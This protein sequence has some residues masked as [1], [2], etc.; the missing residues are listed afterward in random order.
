MTKNRTTF[1]EYFFIDFREEKKQNN[2]ISQRVHMINL[3]SKPVGNHISD[4]RTG[5]LHDRLSKLVIRA[6]LLVEKYI[7]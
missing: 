3:M 4:D 6:S 1:V 7:L 2:H 5:S